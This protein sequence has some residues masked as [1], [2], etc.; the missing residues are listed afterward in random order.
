VDINKTV[1][2][3]KV[4][5]NIVNETN[6]SNV[7]VSKVDISKVVGVDVECK[8]SAFKQHCMQCSCLVFGE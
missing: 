3:M 6:V 8:S 1:D 4:S 5:K 7:A 2:E